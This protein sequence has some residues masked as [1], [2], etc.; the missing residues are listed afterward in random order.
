MP[1][2]LIRFYGPLGGL[3]ERIEI[4]A[5]CC[6]DAEEKVR[7]TR[8]DLRHLH[9]DICRAGG[10]DREQMI[11]KQCGGRVLRKP[12]GKGSLDAEG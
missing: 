1:M 4:F 6:G 3:K 8:P 11:K 7:R 12:V 9:M 5:E 2:Y 10:S